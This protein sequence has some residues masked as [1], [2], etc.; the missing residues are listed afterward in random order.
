M[1]NSGNILEGIRGSISFDGTGKFDCKV[2]FRKP[3]D[4][5]DNTMMHAYLAAALATTLSM[6]F[7]SGAE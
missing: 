6:E 1:M 4:P 7:P 2:H 5:V 3:T